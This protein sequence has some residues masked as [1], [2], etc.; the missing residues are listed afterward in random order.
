[1]S[2]LGPD[3]A[4]GAKRRG[5][6]PRRRIELPNGDYLLPRAELAAELGVS[7]RAVRGMNLPTTY[8]GNVSYVA[9]TASLAVVAARLQRRN[10]PRQRRAAERAGLRRH[11]AEAK[12]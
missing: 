10:Q 11:N 5:R 8:L 4:T 12:K 2:D 9:H 1:M 3:I 7:D 6:Q